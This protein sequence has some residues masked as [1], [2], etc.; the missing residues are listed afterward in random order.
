MKQH[1][2]ALSAMRMAANKGVNPY[3]SATC[4]GAAYAMLWRMQSG[5]RK[6][7]NTDDGYIWFHG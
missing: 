3:D 4:Q 6:A 7:R 2:L 1:K 5:T